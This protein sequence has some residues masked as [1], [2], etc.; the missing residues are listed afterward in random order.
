MSRANVVPIRRETPKI[1]QQRL[2][3]YLQV[4]E[5]VRNE[6]KRLLKWIEAGIPIE[7]GAHRAIVESGKLSVW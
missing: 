4:L 6:E 1:S 2:D 3:D 5:M 7:P